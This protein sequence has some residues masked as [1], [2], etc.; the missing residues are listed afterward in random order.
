MATV[1]ILPKPTKNYPSLIL[2]LF[3]SVLLGACSRVGTTEEVI[4]VA[5][6]NA[7]PSVPPV[8]I[9]VNGAIKEP[10]FAYGAQSGGSVNPYFTLIKLPEDV[11]TLD[12][13][14]A[15]SSQKLISI[16]PNFVAENRYTVVVYDT[17]PNQK[18]LVLQDDN[19]TPASN[20]ARLRFVNLVPNIGQALSLTLNDSAITGSIAFAAASAY[21]DVPAGSYILNAKTTTGLQMR[22]NTAGGMPIALRTKRTYTLLGRG[23]AGVPET[24]LRV[25][26]ITPIT[27]N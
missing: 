10:G 1:M 7:S 3:A 24:D 17:V 22:T 14:P 18:V 26:T 4:Q 6:A 27:N 20:T 23:L 21:I 11:W 12:V 16:A 8:D 19:S 2:M 25:F 15:G 13:K 9:Y 5:F